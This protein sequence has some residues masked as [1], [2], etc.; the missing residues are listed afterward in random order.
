MCPQFFS[1]TKNPSAP[2]K[3]NDISF[4]VVG[5]TARV[6]CNMQSLYDLK[7]LVEF[8]FND[9]AQGCINC[10]VDQEVKQGK[11][12]ENARCG[13]KKFQD[14]VRICRSPANLKVSGKAASRQSW[15]DEGPYS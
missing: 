11:C 12:Q 8:M 7:C 1:N 2:L 5:D 14:A 3:L 4:K 10:G 6:D 15:A 9:N 13:W